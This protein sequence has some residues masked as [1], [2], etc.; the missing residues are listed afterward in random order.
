MVPQEHSSCCLISTK[1]GKEGIL[2]SRNLGSA[3]FSTH[4]HTFLSRL[5]WTCQVLMWTS[6]AKLHYGD[7]VPRLGTLP[8]LIWCWKLSGWDIFGTYLKQGLINYP[9]W[10]TVLGNRSSAADCE[11]DSSCPCFW[12][13]LPP[14]FSWYFLSRGTFASTQDD[15]RKEQENK[16]PNTEEE[17]EVVFLKGLCRRNDYK[18][19]VWPV[20]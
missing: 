7:P 8:K 3:G 10:K 15:L 16:S 14:C 11:G 18:N 19:S 9:P 1:K 20:L 12:T 13:T 4:T 2:Q 6:S 5:L 17:Q